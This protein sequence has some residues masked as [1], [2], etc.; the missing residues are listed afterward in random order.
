MS[1]KKSHRKCHMMRQ[2]RC[3]ADAALGLSN[4]WLALPPVKAIIP[5]R[6]SIG[7]G[8]NG[9]IVLNESI[10]DPSRSSKAI[11]KTYTLKLHRIS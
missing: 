11:Q 9:G 8:Q 1:P 4:A 2:R 5:P 6:G 10:A 3:L 7:F